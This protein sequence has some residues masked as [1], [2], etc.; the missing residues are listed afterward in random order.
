MTAPLQLR[1]AYR[2][3]S[4]QTQKA[5]HRAVGR[6]EIV[7]L[8]PGIYG[9]PGSHESLALR[10]AAL[11]L[12]DPDAII[13]GAAAAHLTWWPDL[14]A[15][16]LTAV[17]R[18]RAASAAGFRWER[19]SIPF[20]LIAESHGLRYTS[21]ALTVLDLIADHGGRP[22]D[23]ALR[24]GAVTLAQV[25]HALDLTP[26][27]RD[28]A[29]R[30]ALLEDS[31]DLPWSEAERLLHRYVRAG[32]HPWPYSTNH[33]VS[34]ADGR[35]AYLDLAMP[36]LKLYL[37]ADGYRYHGP[38]TAFEHDRDRDTDLAAQGWQGHRFSAAFLDHSPEES[39]RRINAIIDHRVRQ[40]GLEPS[41][42]NRP[43]WAQ[44]PR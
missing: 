39:L 9:P 14:P 38:R 44:S 18:Q 34:L 31:C 23:E 3:A 19:R 36:A 22:I 32:R 15:P 41:T 11:R 6:G 37:E 20:G 42:A 24:R 43:G 13:T 35:V 26:R 17:R 10:A 27:R 2:P 8:L 1:D 4:G 29:L 21:P 30:R 12:A 16:L 33:P 28:N 5:A 25:W 40:L 7:R